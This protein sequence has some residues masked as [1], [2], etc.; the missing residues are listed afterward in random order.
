MMKVLI[1]DQPTV[2]EL[3]PMRECVEL[4]ERTLRNLAEGGAT[5]PLRSSM[6]LPEG[7]NRMLLMPSALPSI[8][9]LGAK[10]ITIFPG[11]HGGPFDAHQGVVLLFDD[12]H[13]ALRALVDAT[14]V[15]ALRTAAVSAVATRALARPESAELAI[16]GAGTQGATHL[17]A[18]LLVRPLRRVRVYDPDQ[19]RARRFAERE[20]ERREI[21]VAAVQTAREAVEGADIVCTVTTSP[22]PVLEGRWLK[23]GAHLNAVGAYTPATRELDSETVAR[24][25]LFAD[26]RESLLRESGEFLIPAREGLIGEEHFQGEIGE[27]LTGRVAGRRS[28]EEITLFKALGIAVEDLAAAHH[29]LEQASARGTGTFVEIGAGHFGSG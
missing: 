26:R 14:A 25:R 24:A 21:P 17:E 11:N 16:L 19:D 15:T 6:I 28:S 4:M 29:V 27:V 20:S 9:A 23:P 5:L 13:G 8:G 18:I 1:A 2:A 3:L 12:R 22:E 10:V 7:E